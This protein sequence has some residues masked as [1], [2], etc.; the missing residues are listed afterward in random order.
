MRR[1]AASALG[2]IRDNRATDA[3]IGLLYDHNPQVRQYAVK[4]LGEIGDERALPELMKFED[5]AIPYIK[6]AIDTAIEKINKSRADLDPINALGYTP[7][8][9]STPQTLTNPK[10]ESYGVDIVRVGMSKRDRIE[11]LKQIIR[12]FQHDKEAAPLEDIISKAISSG[13][14]RDAVEDIIRLLKRTGEIY[15]VSNERFRIA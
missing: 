4:A 3:L 10:K 12:E 15:E 8:T 14:E 1:L 9:T 6:K 7:K 11:T 13:I 2:K 5:D